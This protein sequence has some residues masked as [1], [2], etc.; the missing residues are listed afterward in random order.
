MPK[1]CLCPP[2]FPARSFLWVI[3]AHSSLL[4]ILPN[5]SLDALVV[6]AL[7]AAVSPGLLEVGAGKVTC[8]LNAY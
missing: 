1:P 6:A 8:F 2:G 3:P 5:S 4:L 7:L